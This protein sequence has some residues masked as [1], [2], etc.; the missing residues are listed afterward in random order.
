MSD[1]MGLSGAARAVLE[2][3]RTCATPRRRGWRRCSRCRWRARRDHMRPGGPIPL[4]GGIGYCHEPH[5]VQIAG[6]GLPIP[7]DHVC[8]AWRW[9]WFGL[10]CVGVDLV[11]EKAD[12]G[13]RPEVPANVTFKEAGGNGLHNLGLINREIGRG[14]D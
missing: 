6:V 9:N 11:V 4:R 12:H 3:P 7:D 13:G 8:P 1:A 5:R 2:E 10:R 14:V